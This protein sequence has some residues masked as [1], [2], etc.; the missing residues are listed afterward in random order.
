MAKAAIPSLVEID[1][2]ELSGRK[3]LQV[4]HASPNGGECRIQWDGCG[5]T[6]YTN[7]RVRVRDRLGNEKE[8]K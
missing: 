5:W 8:A 7:E 6:I 3:W 2:V 1:Y 4:Y